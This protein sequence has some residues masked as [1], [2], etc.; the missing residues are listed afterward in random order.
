MHCF[1]ISK[2]SDKHCYDLFSSNVGIEKAFSGYQ[3]SKVLA[4]LEKNNDANKET[5]VI[6]YYLIK[7]ELYMDLHKFLQ[8]CI[9]KNKD[10]IKITD[11]SSYFDYLKKLSKLHKK[12]YKISNHYLKNTTRMTCL[13]I[14]LF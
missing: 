9:H 12:K 7:T 4:L 11:I 3:T 13:E 10:I 5:N 6:S 1:L 14:D 8:F 2:L